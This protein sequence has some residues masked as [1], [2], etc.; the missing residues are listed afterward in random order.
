M[1]KSCFISMN[2]FWILPITRRLYKG[3]SVIKLC[4]FW[5]KDL[6]SFSTNWQ[7]CKLLYEFCVLCFSTCNGRLALPKKPGSSLGYLSSWRYPYPYGAFFSIS[8]TTL[9]RSCRNPSS[10]A[11]LSCHG[12]YN[13]SVKLLFDFLCCYFFYQD[14]MDGPNL[15]LG[16]CELFILKSKPN[17]CNFY[18]LL[19]T[20][21]KSCF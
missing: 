10:G 9:S 5:V 4:C 6:Y 18:R 15:Q 16:Q 21:K 3:T 20:L 2:T 12:I 7:K 13:I 8:F 11:D 17:F 19:L 14:I 1:I